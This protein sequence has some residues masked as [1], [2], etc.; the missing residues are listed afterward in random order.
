MRAGAAR[1]VTSLWSVQDESAA[2]LIR[3]F[4]RALLVER[5]EPGAALRQAQLAVSAVARWRSPRHWAGFL[6]AGTWDRGAPAEGTGTRE[7]TIETADK[8]GTGGGGKPDGSFPN[9]GDLG[10]SDAGGVA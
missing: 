2:E 8:G 3:R 6:C 7:G 4:Y 1:V 9:P 5:L 10:A